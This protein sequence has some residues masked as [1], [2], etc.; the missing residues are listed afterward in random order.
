VAGALKSEGGLR[1]RFGEKQVRSVADF[2][3]RHVGGVAA[4]LVLGFGLAFAPEVGRFFGLP[5][6][7]RHVT[8][9]TGSLS[10]AVA[11][12]GLAPLEPGAWAGMLAGIVVIGVC[13]L[14]VSFV[15]A[16]GTAL[17]ARRIPAARGFALLGKTTL[18]ILRR[19][20]NLLRVP[21]ADLPHD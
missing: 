16:F 13:N 21:P 10:L 5:L 7:V 20:G 8:L 4:A 12:L 14:G 15:L 19:P 1:V 3:S 2:L 17:R 9:V 11:A 6:E 18:S